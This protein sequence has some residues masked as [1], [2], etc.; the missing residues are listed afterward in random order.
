MQQ[1]HGLREQCEE[2]ARPLDRIK[3]YHMLWVTD[4]RI[5]MIEECMNLARSN[6]E[7]RRQ[8]VSTLEELIS[9][10][11]QLI[12]L[13]QVLEDAGFGDADSK[14]LV[15]IVRISLQ[16]KVESSELL[17]RT[18]LAEAQVSALREENE[19]LKGNL[20]S[21]PKSDQEILITMAS[22]V[23][24]AELA[25]AQNLGRFRLDESGALFLQTRLQNTIALRLSNED[26]RAKFVDLIN[27]ADDAK[28]I[29]RDGKQ[30]C[31]FV[32]VQ[33]NL[34]AHEGIRENEVRARVALALMAY[35]LA[36]REL[37]SK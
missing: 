29:S 10:K 28:I 8:F 6:L 16:D 35:A 27:E 23:M 13:H 21:V 7:V 5:R 4:D 15:S 3:P 12:D 17:A 9:C 19:R 2:Q 37:V 11:E 33:R 18:A 26:Q 20:S 1:T 32:R 24:G 30:F 36:M 22:E 25:N 31:H 14:D 34:I